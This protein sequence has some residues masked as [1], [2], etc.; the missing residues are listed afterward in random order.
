MIPKKYSGDELKNKFC[1]PV[2]KIRNGGGAAISPETICRIVSVVRG[3]GFTIETEKCPRCG[4]SAYIS[5][6]SRDDL[7]LVENP[8]MEDLVNDGEKS[9]EHLQSLCDK[10][11]QIIHENDGCN[12]CNGDEAL[13]YQNGDTNAFIDSK[14]NIDVMIDGTTMRFT[15]NN[16]PNCGRAFDKEN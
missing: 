15:V 9:I 1:R 3:H 5:R 8:M 6:V 12:C 14:G 11:D 4:Q 16:C 7:E 10:L 13:F 2:R